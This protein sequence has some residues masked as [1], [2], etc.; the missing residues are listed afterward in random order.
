MSILAFLVMMLP[1]LA[2]RAWFGRQDRDPLVT[3]A[4]TIGISLAAIILLAE[5]G[6]LIGVSFST[7][8]IILLAVLFAGLALAGIIRRGF[9]WPRKFRWYLW[10]GLPL[11]GLTIAWRLYQAWGLLLPSWVDSQHHFLI[12]RSII[13]NG[14][15]PE[16]LAPYL[17]MPFYYHYGFHAVAALYTAI[18]GLEIGQAMLILGQILNAL[19]G[20]SVYALGKALWK[21]W[22]PAAAAA[23]LVTFVTRMP[24]YY[25]SWGRYTLTMGMIFLP[26]AMGTALRLLRK[27]HRK[28]DIALLALLT[29]G[30]LLSHYF[31]GLLLA[32]F[33]VIFAVLYFIPR[34][35]KML[36]AMTNLK[37]I[38]IGA[39][40][41]LLLALPWLLRVAH[42]SSLSTGIE[43]NLGSIASGSSTASYIWKLLGPTSNYALLIPAIIGLALALTKKI[44]SAFSIWSLFLAVFALPWT[45]SLRPFR[46]DHFAIVLFLPATLWAGWLFLQSGR[47]LARRFQRRWVCCVFMLILLVGWIAWSFPLSADIVNQVT[48]MVTEDDLDALDWVKENTP[49]DARFYINTAYWQ[50][51]I[52]RGVDGGGWLLPYTGRWALV[53]TVFYGF[54]PDIDL[55]IQT[56]GWGKEASSITTCSPEFWTLVDETRLSWIYVHEGIGGMQPE[57]LFNCEGIKIAYTVGLVSIYQIIK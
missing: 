10:I 50:T 20:L 3:L 40:L 38:I 35:R 31:A 18:S 25:L 47:W 28:T 27:P 9:H 46:A 52:Y 55:K 37:G 33:L 32:I 41:G 51:D 44:P 7:F 39:F 16:T 34:L 5:I 48:V 2:W 56:R 14:C 19:I 4:Q 24:A 42:Y 30:A 43:S 45:F 22:R 57:N 11:F 21:D 54:S 15:L 17:D 8:G 6:F 13:E 12:V 23:L 53:P 1:G 36:T 26:L 49:E 29:A